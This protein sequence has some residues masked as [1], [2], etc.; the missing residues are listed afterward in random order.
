[1]PERG[2]GSHQIWVIDEASMVGSV[3]MSG[4]MKAAEKAGA[5]VVLIGDTKQMQASTQGNMF[6][7]LQESGAMNTVRMDENIR[8]KG[9]PEYQASHEGHC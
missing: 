1:M 8:Q 9:S 3:K 2:S 7:K 5:K 6:S 4:I